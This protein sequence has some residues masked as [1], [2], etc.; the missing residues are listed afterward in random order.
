[1]ADS[2]YGSR[3]PKELKTFESPR[4]LVLV[5]VILQLFKRKRNIF[6]MASPHVTVTHPGFPSPS[7]VP[8]G[9]V[10]IIF[11]ASFKLT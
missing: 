9:F 1:M 5:K 7:R 4:V 2:K 6:A 11:I 3:S 10:Y 8:N